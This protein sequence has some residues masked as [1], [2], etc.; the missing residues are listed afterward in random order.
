MAAAVAKASGKGVRKT[1]G[2]ARASGTWERVMAVLI[3][4]FGP[5]FLHAWGAGE[6]GK[7]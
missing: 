7:K 6:H 3:V 2:P 4:N 1:N 5:E